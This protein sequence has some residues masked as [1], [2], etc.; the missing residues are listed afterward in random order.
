MVSKTTTTE[1]S[2][3]KIL[4]E[5]LIAVVTMTGV[6]YAALAYTDRSYASQD[7]VASL[8]KRQDRV[9]RVQESIQRDVANINVTQGRMDSK[10]DTLIQIAKDEDNR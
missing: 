2:I 10:L 5:V 1:N 9:E 8:E 7:R 3:L 6:V 4:L